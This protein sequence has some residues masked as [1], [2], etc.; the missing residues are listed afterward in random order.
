MVV[1]IW[2]IFAHDGSE[3]TYF[4]N[5]QNVNNTFNICILWIFIF[6]M[7]DFY[8]AY[9]RVFQAATKSLTERLFSYDRFHHFLRIS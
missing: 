6:Q 9:F 1:N 3:N 2:N 8:C 7:D 5:T 4:Q